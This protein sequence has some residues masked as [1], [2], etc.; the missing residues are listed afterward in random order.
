MLSRTS[1]GKTITDIQI[2]VCLDTYGN[3]YLQVDQDNNNKINDKNLMYQINI[4]NKDEIYFEEGLYQ[5]IEDNEIDEHKLKKKNKKRKRQFSN[6][7]IQNKK[8]KDKDNEDSDDN[9]EA[10]S[11]EDNSDND[12][13]EG[14]EDENYDCDYDYENNLAKHIKKLF[15]ENCNYKILPNHKYKEKINEFVFATME[16]SIS[17]KKRD[18]GLELALY[19]CIIYD[20]NFNVIFT[21]SADEYILYRL[22]IYNDGRLVFRPIGGENKHYAV[23][24][25]DNKPEL[26]RI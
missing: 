13:N 5:E 7:L 12:E 17:V 25:N 16:N 26:I 11:E 20:N 22:N 14:D 24:V 3:T 23:Y 1:D 15:P 19:D 8:N 21:S 6:V 18:G 4:D 9:S 10:D 2:N